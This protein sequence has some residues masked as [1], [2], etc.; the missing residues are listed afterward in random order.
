MAQ[1]YSEFIATDTREHVGA[2]GFRG[3]QLSYLPQQFVTGS[4]TTGVVDHLEAVEI[5]E[6]QYVS[7]SAGMHLIQCVTDRSLELGAIRYTGQ[8]VMRGLIGETVMQPLRL[9]HVAQYGNSTARLSATRSYR[10]HSALYRNWLASGHR[11][12]S[13]QAHRRAH[14]LQRR[15]YRIRMRGIDLMHQR[16]YRLDATTNRISTHK[17]GQL[18]G[19][20][21]QVADLS[22]GINH[23][24]GLA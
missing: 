12:K 14:A 21:V 2:T 3:Q 7:A 20:R 8:Q 16:Q 6:Q 11:Q 22:I 5:E 1:Q 17:A 18:L 13:G 4:M 9:G 10:G 15:A 19:C 24:H 23:Q